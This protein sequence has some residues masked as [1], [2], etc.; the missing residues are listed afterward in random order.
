MVSSWF[1]GKRVKSG[2]PWNLRQDNVRTVE[3]EWFEQKLDTQLTTDGGEEAVVS[4]GGPPGEEA[5]DTDS[6]NGDGTDTR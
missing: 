3:W 4:D 5:A 2:D 1:E 6:S